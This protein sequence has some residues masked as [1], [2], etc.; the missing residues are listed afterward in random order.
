MAVILTMIL[1]VTGTISPALAA[2]FPTE[3]EE[4]VSAAEFYAEEITDVA[5]IPDVPDIEEE[6]DIPAEAAALPTDDGLIDDAALPNDDAAIPPA[7]NLTIEQS[8]EAESVS[9]TPAFP[10]K[11]MTLSNDTF[12]YFVSDDPSFRRSYWDEND[13]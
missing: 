12:L 3:T 4:L 7:P 6:A 11:S 1:M 13:D 5:A 2:E 8:E 9:A 10:V